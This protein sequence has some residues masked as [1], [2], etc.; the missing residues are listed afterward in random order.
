MWKP[1]MSLNINVKPVGNAR[2]R[3]INDTGTFIRQSA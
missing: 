1:S 3:V 2:V